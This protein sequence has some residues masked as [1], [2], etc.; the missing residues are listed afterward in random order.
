MQKSIIENGIKKY[1]MKFV[2]TPRRIS[3]CKTQSKSYIK[4]E[5]YKVYKC[6]NQIKFQGKFQN[7][8]EEIIESEDVQYS[9]NVA[10]YNFEYIK[11]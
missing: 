8:L 9:F 5:I 7:D 10:T 6:E 3:T 1:L 11:E 2:G 4:N